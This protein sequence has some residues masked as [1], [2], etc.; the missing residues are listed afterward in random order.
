[1]S[2]EQTLTW[3]EGVRL[4][5]GDLVS[6]PTPGRRWW[7]FWKPKRKIFRVTKTYP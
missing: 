2:D 5:T 6:V 3:S 7:Q 4:N 1:M